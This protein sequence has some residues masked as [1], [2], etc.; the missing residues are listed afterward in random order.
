MFCCVFLNENLSTY[1]F[2]RKAWI[3][4]TLHTQ[5]VKSSLCRLLSQPST[6]ELYCKRF[7][8]AHAFWRLPLE[9]ARSSCQKLHKHHVHWLWFRGSPDCLEH[10]YQP[11]LNKERARL[12]SAPHP[13]NNCTVIHDLVE[14]QEHF[15]ALTFQWEI[16][17][18]TNPGIKLGPASVDTVSQWVLYKTNTIDEDPRFQAQKC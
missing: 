8:H 15:Y 10:R 12:Y 3:Q 11:G 6:S 7:P 5:M 4:K 9:V 17:L 14:G 13:R 16:S 2:K 1:Y 18:P